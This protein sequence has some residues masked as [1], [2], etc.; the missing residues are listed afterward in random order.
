MQYPD[1]RDRMCSKIASKSGYGLFDAKSTS[2]G[3]ALSSRGNPE[4]PST[5]TMAFVPLQLEHW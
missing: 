4:A 2:N 3:E 5:I 1:L